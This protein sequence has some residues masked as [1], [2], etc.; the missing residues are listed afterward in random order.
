MFVNFNEITAN[1]LTNPCS[2]D[3]I[4]KFD[5][6]E[7]D[8]GNIKLLTHIPTVLLRVGNFDFRYT[9]RTVR[10]KNSNVSS[11]FRCYPL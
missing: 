7:F 6:Y 8:E 4:K 5:S 3:L 1:I 10:N 2:S 9:Y 11:K